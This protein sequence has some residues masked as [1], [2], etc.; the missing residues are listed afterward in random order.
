MN[1][2]VYAFT[3]LKI[4]NAGIKEI[5]DVIKDYEHLRQIDL[6]FNLLQEIPNVLHLKYVVKLELARNQLHNANFLS[7]ESVFPYLKYINLQ[8]NK[9]TAL[10]AVALRN[11]RRLN[12]NQNVI[13][14]LEDFD[15]HPVLEILELRANKLKSL[16]GL[17]NVPGLSELYVAE[18]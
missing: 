11:L 10:P 16:K 5:T 15:G 8:G 2:K 17:K 14:T 18:N 13:A 6:S 9:I 3:T 4:R 7:R 1:G 12:L